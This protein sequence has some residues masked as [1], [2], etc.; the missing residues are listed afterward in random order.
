MPAPSGGGDNESIATQAPLSVDGQETYGLYIAPGMGYRIDDAV[1]TAFGDEPEGEYAIFGREHYNGGCCFDYGQMESNSLDTGD[2]SMEALYYGTESTWSYG[3]NPGPWPETDQENNL[4][5]G[6][7]SRYN[8]GDL[9]VLPFTPFS[10]GAMTTTPTT[11]GQFLTDFLSGGSKT[12]AT[13]N[14]QWEFRTGNAQAGNL[15]TDYNG[16]RTWYL[17]T[18]YNPMVKHGSDGVGNGGDNSDGSDGT[19]YEGVMTSGYPTDATTNAVAANITAAQYEPS[20]LSLSQASSFSPSTTHNVTET[21]TNYTALTVTGVQLTAS[22]PAGW[23]VTASGS[24]SFASVAPGASVSATFTVGSPSATGNATLTGTATWS[25]PGSSTPG[26]YQTTQLLRNT[27][28]IKINEIRFSTTTPNN[29]SNQYVELYNAGATNVNIGNYSLQYYASGATNLNIPLDTIPAGTTVAPNSYYVV[30]RSA[31]TLAAPAVGGTNIVYVTS[32]TGATNLGA[33]NALIIDPGP[34]QEAATITTVGTAASAATAIFRP[35]RTGQFVTG[36]NQPF[37]N[38]ITI[39]AGSTNVPVV[40]TTGFTVGQQMTIGLPPNQQQVTV[41]NVGRAGDSTYLADGNPA[42][43]G[44]TNIRPNSTTGMTV[45][46]TVWLVGTGSETPL[47]TESDVITSITGSTVGLQTPLTDAFAAGS[48]G[49]WDQATGISFTP[50]TSQAYSSNAPV[51]ALGTGLKL[52]NN[53]ASSHPFGAPVLD[54]A[55]TTAGYQGTPNQWFSTTLSTTGALA[56]VDPTGLDVDSLNFTTGNT[57]TIVAPLWEEGV[58]TDGGPNTLT[59]G[60]PAVG[61]E[62]PDDQLLRAGVRRW[63]SFPVV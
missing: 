23:T 49:V 24:T 61:P 22:A 60:G 2:G 43:V 62:L 3:P 27:Q 32:T 6:D 29:A 51:Q 21:F 46:D 36:Q 45:G 28:P 58:S 42:A 56:L 50:A 30:G 57:G 8:F 44:A 13:P 35:L 14:G 54:P 7:F 17:T 25:N 41:T 20:L 40:S 1:N 59:P 53:L 19:W 33:T 48:T 39:P 52:A 26:T 15:T 5:S 18:D 11:S 37:L 55:A 10:N 63:R 47:N 16:P 9:P 12:A 4:V 31:S 34:N 38:Q